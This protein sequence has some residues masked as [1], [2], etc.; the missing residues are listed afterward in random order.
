MPGTLGCK[1][2][3]S[4]G[5]EDSTALAAA[6]GRHVPPLHA[7]RAPISPHLAARLEGQR[8]SL[9][10]LVAWLAVL[11]SPL[12]VESAGGL[13]SPLTDAGETNAELAAQLGVPVV[14]VAPNRLGVL[15]DVASALRASAAMSLPIAAVVLTGAQ[16]LRD[17]AS[18][19][20]NKDEL[21]RLHPVPIYSAAAPALAS[22]LTALHRICFPA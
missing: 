13:F 10:A 18:T 14:L 3:E 4:G 8:I 7:L 12:L 16:A 21:R 6:C 11:P 15:H 1:P 19:P 5:S 17:D 2:I 20:T 22:T 9:S